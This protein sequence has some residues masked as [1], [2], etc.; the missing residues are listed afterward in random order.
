MRGAASP[1]GI[2][3]ERPV[4]RPH[5]P[6]PRWD[7]TGHWTLRR[8]A[9]PSASDE[10]A[11]LCCWD[12]RVS[13]PEEHLPPGTTARVS[14]PGHAESVRRHRGRRGQLP[15]DGE[16]R[17]AAETGASAPSERSERGPEPGGSGGTPG[18]GAGV[19]ARGQGAG[20]E[21]AGTRRE[22][23]VMTG[24]GPTAQGRAGAG[25]RPA[26]LG[27]LRG[28]RRALR[29]YGSG[30]A[31]PDRPRRLG[32]GGAELGPPRPAALPARSAS[33]RSRVRRRRELVPPPRAPETLPEAPEDPR[34]PSPPAP[35][36]RVRPPGPAPLSPTPA[37]RIPATSPA[38]TCRR[39]GAPCYSEAEP[40]DAAGASGSDAR[41]RKS[42]PPRRKSRRKFRA[43][44]RAPSW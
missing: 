17:S 11:S 4:L 25:A 28:S 26:G 20:S 8:S 41:R 43:P 39:E 2:R 22:R 5:H 13:E 35:P 32:A 6:A 27:R 23:G 16:R 14:D 33:S 34:T 36:S 31:G 29:L 30:D 42:R 3:A 15:A 9:Q 24:H 18:S 12:F 40:G 7:T 44:V 10:A 37:P 19:E 1:G 21:A 38:G